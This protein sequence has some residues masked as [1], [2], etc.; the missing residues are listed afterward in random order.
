MTTAAAPPP[1]DPAAIDAAWK[2]VRA[3]GDIQ[4]DFPWRDV[5]PEPDPQWLR[6]LA[7]TLGRFFTALGPI[8]EV[9]FYVMLAL[10]AVVLFVSLYPPAR[11]ALVAWWQR[12][13]TR[14]EAPPEWRPAPA[15]AR[16]LLAEADRLAADGDYGQAVHLLLLRSIED[17]ERWQGN[18]VGTALTAR[19]IAAAT[20][21]P[22]AARPVFSRLVAVV[23]RALFGQC[24]VSATEWQGARD[25]YRGFAL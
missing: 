8:W 4:F 25:A 22:A 19:D 12:R 16:A 14:P 17:I 24:P 9:L 5:A 10:L 7:D 2:Q 15:Q 20:A 11:E 6:A 18:P 13:R 21:L 3:D 23:E 1:P